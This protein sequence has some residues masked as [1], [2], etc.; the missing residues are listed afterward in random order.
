MNNQF[1]S[2]ESVNHADIDNLEGKKEDILL[3][4]D[5]VRPCLFIFYKLVFLHTRINIEPSY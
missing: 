3:N 2:R 1:I 5:Y 4:K